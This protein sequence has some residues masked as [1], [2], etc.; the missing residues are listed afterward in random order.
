MSWED[1]ESAMTDAVVTASGYPSGQVLWSYQN[2]TEPQLDFIVIH[3]GGERTLGVDRVCISTDL[4][5]PNGQEIKQEIRGVREVPFTF[6]VYTSDRTGEAAARRVA[7]KI[8]TKLR[9]PSIRYSLRAVGLSPFDPGPVQYVPDV[10]STDFR[11]RAICTVRCY[12][13]VLDCIE[14]TGYIARVVGTFVALGAGPLY[15]SGY[16]GT[17]DSLRASGATGFVPP[18]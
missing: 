8:R 7:E 1:I 9:L 15:P 13:P 18:G 11:G 5:R 10:P 3:F 14:Y 2:V 12:I 4:G 17:F 6:T 16:T